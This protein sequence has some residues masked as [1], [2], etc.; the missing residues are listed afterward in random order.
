MDVECHWIFLS[1]KTPLGY[2]GSICDGPKC[3]RSLSITVHTLSVW[4]PLSLSC[5]E[6]TRTHTYKHTFTLPH[7]HYFLSFHFIFKSRSVFHFA[8]F[9]FRRF[10]IICVVFLWKCFLSVLLFFWCCC[11]HIVS[12]ISV[13]CII[14]HINFSVYFLWDEMF[15]RPLGPY[16]HNKWIFCVLSFI[17]KHA[18]SECWRPVNSFAV[19]SVP[20]AEMNFGRFQWTKRHVCWGK[21]KKSSPALASDSA[22]CT[23]LL[24]KP[25]VFYFSHTSPHCVIIWNWSKMSCVCLCCLVEKL[26]LSSSGSLRLFTSPC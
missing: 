15:W 10:F 11:C 20:A 1:K 18:L 9:P 13:F 4:L 19:G 14:C 17:I 8:Y 25:V 3:W 12:F 23:G 6:P 5:F 16:L 2:K 7:S 26:L 21:K 22:V 24:A